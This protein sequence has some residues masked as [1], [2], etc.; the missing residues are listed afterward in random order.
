MANV[1]AHVKKK[2][3]VHTVSDTIVNLVKQK[4]KKT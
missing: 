4:V 3:A 1:A 2:H